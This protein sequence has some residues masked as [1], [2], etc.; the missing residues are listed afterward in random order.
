MLH[1]VQVCCSV[2]VGVP[3]ILTPLLAPT[4]TNSLAGYALLRA[5]LIC[6]EY[7]CSAP[8]PRC[9]CVSV[10]VC[11]CVCAREVMR[12]RILSTSQRI[13]STSRIRCEHSCSAPF[14][15]CVRVCARETLRQRILSASQVY[16]KFSCSVT[17]PH[18]MCV[19]VCV[20]ERD[21]ATENFKRITRLLRMILRFAISSPCV[22]VCVCVCVRER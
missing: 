18:R 3:S 12:Q 6:C 13:L 17:F 19:Y 7:S 22:C 20:C 1:H 14:P 4:N 11:V 15:R 10:C 21:N 16:G 5:S 2:A 8:F 9:V